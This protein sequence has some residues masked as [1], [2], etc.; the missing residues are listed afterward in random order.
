MSKST[1]FK[2]F[3]QTAIAFISAGIAISLTPSRASS[4]ETVIFTYGGLTQSIPI[5]EL[6]D[7]ADTGEVSPALDTLLKHGKQ[8]P[9]VIRWILKQ[10]FPANNKLIADLL[11]TASGEYI[12]SQTENV[13]SSKTER[14]NVTALRG[15]LIASASDNNLVS[16]L[17]LLE[18]YPTQDVYVNGKILARLQENFAQFVE[19]TS[20]YI[21]IPWNMPEIK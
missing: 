17:E 10:E 5:G 8:N 3:R 19:G 16:L 21:K 20:Q 6:Q 11:N 9:F 1:L 14:A 15:A 12:L 18:N 7:F 13:V 4:S 2:W